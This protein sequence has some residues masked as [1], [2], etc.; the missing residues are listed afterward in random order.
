MDGVGSLSDVHT[1]ENCAR[2]GLKRSAGERE[3]PEISLRDGHVDT[4]SDLFREGVL[5][6]RMPFGMEAIHER[7]SGSFRWC[8]RR[9]I[10]RSFS[11]LAIMVSVFA[12]QSGRGIEHTDQGQ[13]WPLSAGVM[14]KA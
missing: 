11:A 4:N 14:T 3:F 7:K 2:E 13:R 6:P 1:R 5:T 9:C 10:L 8:I 12:V